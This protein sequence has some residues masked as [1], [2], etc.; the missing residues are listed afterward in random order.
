MIRT[1]SSSNGTLE[2]L[3]K[4]HP[5]TYT[6]IC[7]HTHKRRL[8]ILTEIIF[9]LK[10]NLP[11]FSIFIIFSLSIQEYG[12]ISI[13][14]TRDSFSSMRMQVNFIIAI[15]ITYSNLSSLICIIYLDYSHH[16]KW[17]DKVNWKYK[18]LKVLKA[19]VAG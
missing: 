5:P 10:V 1:V 17:K 19:G 3:Y 8:R 18:H 16:F 15:L 13:Y 2:S 6:Y 14:S 11:K 7:P 12:Y 4:S 9:H